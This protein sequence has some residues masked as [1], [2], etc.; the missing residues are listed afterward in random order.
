MGIKRILYFTI[1][2][3]LLLISTFNIY[4]QVGANVVGSNSAAAK[5]ITLPQGNI[6]YCLAGT[7]GSTLNP[8]FNVMINNAGYA[9]I[10]NS[11][12]NSCSFTTTAQY[13]VIGGVSVNNYS[14]PVILTNFT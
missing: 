2:S 11:S 13:Y 14:T 6:Y 4:S 7:G 10:G 12:T 5:S 8:N 3:F 1:V 9:I